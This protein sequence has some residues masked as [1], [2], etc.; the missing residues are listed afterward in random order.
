MKAALAS[1][2]RVAAGAPAVLALVLLV[3]CGGGSS[4]DAAVVVRDAARKT[5]AAGSA[6][7]ALMVGL[8]SSSS[9]HGDGVFD[10]AGGRGDISLDLGGA[11]GSL[12][13]GQ[14]ET[15]IDQSGLYV[16]LPPGLVSASKPWVKVDLAS[17][18]GLAGV[19]LGS[20]SELRSTDPSQALQ[21]LQGAVDDMRKVGK[22]KVRDAETTHY[23]GALDLKKAAA[24][25][26]AQAQ[27][28]LNQSVDALGT[29]SLPADVWIDAQGRMRKLR[30]Q[31]DSDGSGPKPATSVEVEMYDFGVAVDA[32]APPANQVTDLASI[33]GGVPKK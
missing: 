22:E 7:V 27:D 5:T 19:D 1:R 24:A 20:L 11:G 3:A 8:P 28:A 14:L 18:A 26:P 30:F 4:G 32:Q 25:A 13:S 16:K 29:S 21:F 33:L 17:V 9:V 6:R 15:Y 31:I 23:R 10:L 12:L 2:P